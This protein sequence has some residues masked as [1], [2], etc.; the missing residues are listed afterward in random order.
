MLRIY[1]SGIY[2]ANLMTAKEYWWI[3]DFRDYCTAG[4][5]KFAIN[6]SEPA[7]LPPLQLPPG[8]V[9]SPPPPP[10]P[11][12]LQ[13]CQTRHKLELFRYFSYFVVCFSY[14]WFGFSFV[15]TWIALEVT[16]IIFCVSVDEVNLY[17]HF[18]E[19]VSEGP[20]KVNYLFIF[21]YRLLV[22][23]NSCI[24]ACTDVENYWICFSNNIY[25]IIFF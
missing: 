22:E 2:T 6:V 10:P 8:D 3:W 12:Q 23:L 9:T 11:P 17:V 16:D 1:D 18:L 24:L 19:S 14:H 13:S 4:G 21:S 5:I 20:E 25:S 15:L 7:T